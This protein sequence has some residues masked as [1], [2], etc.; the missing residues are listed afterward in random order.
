MADLQVDTPARSAA[1]T[2][3]Q[4]ASK[5][6]LLDSL[7][8]TLSSVKFG[9]VLLIVLA[10][11]S[12]IGTFIVQEG[13]SDFQK[14]YESL[15]PAEKTVYQ[16]LGFMDIYHT[17]YFNLLLLVLSLNITLATIDRLPGYWHFFISPKLSITEQFAKY[18]PYYVKLRFRSVAFEQLLQV[19]SDSCRQVLM[20]RWL[21]LLGPLGGLLAKLTFFR[22]A[23]TS[24]KDSKTFFIE[25][26]V[27]NRYAFCAVHLAL[28]LILIGWF[29]GN[30]WGQKGI[31]QFQPGQV[32]E[33]F[34]SPGANDTVRTFKL[35]FKMTCVDISQDL[36]DKRK[37]DL[38]PQNTLDWHTVIVFEVNGKRFKGDIHLNEPIDFMGY[39]FFQA[40]FDQITSA[41]QMTLLFMPKTGKGE[42]LEVVLKRNGATDVPGVGKILWRDFYPDF[43]MDP[44]TRKP[45]TASGEYVRP[46]AEFAVQA[47]DGTVKPALAFTEDFLKG[48]SS[49][50]PFLA[51]MISVGDYNVVLKDF[52]KVSR[53]HTL[54]V[55]YDP[56]VDMVYWGFALLVLFLFMVFFFAHERV[57]VLVKPEDGELVLCMAGNT[58]RNKHAFEKR[59]L[60]ILARL[61]E[62]EVL[63]S[64]REGRSASDHN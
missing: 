40:S 8:D 22:S 26:G 32:S 46:V 27:W 37:P 31:I 64:R 13:T 42:S 49:N 61:P 34:F 36:I 20:P 44:E 5:K 12:S 50:A 45:F 24:D 59:F 23:L 28:L 15:T 39:R 38:S 10:V 35:P 21:R 43:R 14:F 30:R 16:V 58:N 3:E 48:I 11:L 56:G 54:Q 29:I 62:A 19:A 1:V 47:A 4:K 17:W 63:E 9:I 60:S 33:V 55:Q 7:L 57:W 52:E 51:E 25:R 41:R 2:V 53:S 6:G 18:Q